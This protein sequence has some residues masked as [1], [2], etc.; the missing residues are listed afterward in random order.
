MVLRASINVLCTAENENKIEQFDKENASVK[1]EQGEIK[2][3]R[4]RKEKK[5]GILYLYC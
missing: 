4:G 3:K 1:M 5:H 2:K